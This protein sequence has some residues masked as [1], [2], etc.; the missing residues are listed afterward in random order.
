[1]ALASPEAKLVLKEEGVPELLKKLSD[2]PDNKVASMAALGLK[3]FTKQEA[4]DDSS[5]A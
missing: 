1:M 4:T 3:E 2:D 5:P